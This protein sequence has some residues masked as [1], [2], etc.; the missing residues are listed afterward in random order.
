MKFTLPV[1]KKNTKLEKTHFQ[2][3]T[4]FQLPQNL[5]HKNQ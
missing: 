1:S 5:P 2:A 3:I 4:I